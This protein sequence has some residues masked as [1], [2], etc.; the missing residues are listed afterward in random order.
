MLVHLLEQTNSANRQIFVVV[1]K[2]NV[3]LGINTQS[4]VQNSN[5]NKPQQSN[6][7]EK[8]SNLN[9]AQATNIANNLSNLN[10][11]DLFAAMSNVKVGLAEAHA[12]V[13]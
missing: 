6:A 8:A 10:G 4:A 9:G 5:V 13:G 1:K 2:M 7:G 3:N 11:G 12:L